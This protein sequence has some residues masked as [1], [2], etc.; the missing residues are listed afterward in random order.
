LTSGVRLDHSV[1]GDGRD[2]TPHIE[3]LDTLELRLLSRG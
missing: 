1:L 3:E 2:V